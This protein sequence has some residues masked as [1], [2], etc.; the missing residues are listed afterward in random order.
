[1]RARSAVVLVLAF[2]LAPR[3]AAAQDQTAPPEPV[4][5][6]NLGPLGLTPSMTFTNVGIDTNV[7]N[8]PVDPKRDFSATV[9]PKID[10]RLRVRSLRVTG[11]TSIDTV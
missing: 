9:T 4:S 8:E 10:A 1:M 7:F 2:A 11:S 6:F 3:A 5:R